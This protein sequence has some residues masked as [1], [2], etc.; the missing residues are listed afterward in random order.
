MIFLTTCTSLLVCMTITTYGFS[1]SS[2]TLNTSFKSE[3]LLTN[4]R[5]IPITIK[6]KTRLNG[7]GD[8]FK[9]AFSNDDNL[10]KRKDE[11]LAS[12]P[13][14]NKNVSVNGKKIPGAVIGQKLTVVAGYA[15]VKIPVN[16]QK[17]NCGTCMVKMN[18]KNVKAC[19]TAVPKGKC[20]VKT[21]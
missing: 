13:D 6:K 20:A 16:C 10:G 2:R 7:F 11:G 1:P 12:G 19:Q 14:Y 18:G 8:A 17:G 4:I 5:R 3:G 15:R 21:L 9:G